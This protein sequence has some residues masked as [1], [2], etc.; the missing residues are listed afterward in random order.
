MSAAGGTTPPQT[1]A[2]QCASNRRRYDVTRILDGAASAADLQATLARFWIAQRREVTH[3][4]R[5]SA[6]QR[7]QYIARINDVRVASDD[8][9]YELALPTN[10]AALS[11][12]IAD[13]VPA[14]GAPGAPTLAS[15][16]PNVL[17]GYMVRNHRRTPVLL[18]LLDRYWYSVSLP[19]TDTRS[20]IDAARINVA[21][22]PYNYV[23][24]TDGGDTATDT[25]ARQTYAEYAAIV[26]ASQLDVVMRRATAMLTVPPTHSTWSYAYEAYL[27]A[28]CSADARR[29]QRADARAQAGKLLAKA[30]TRLQTAARRT[31]APVEARRRIFVMHIDDDA[32]HYGPAGAYSPAGPLG[33]LRGAAR[34]VY[35]TLRDTEPTWHLYLDTRN[36]DYLYAIV[37][38]ARLASIANT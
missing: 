1:F 12:F 7:A 17:L 36:G 20:L 10:P 9:L 3:V 33:N 25:K 24:R 2:A 38:A 35:E 23:W 8:A 14:R 16:D 31:D 32:G 27:R 21:S 37:P 29:K 11:T 28:T 15:Y 5:S 13:N 30:Y 26:N 6:A 19:G 22:A 34:V 18:E 4:L